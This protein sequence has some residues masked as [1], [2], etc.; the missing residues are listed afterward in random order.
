MWGVYAHL[1]AIPGIQLPILAQELGL[2]HCNFTPEKD[3]IEILIT[4]QR[5]MRPRPML[6]GFF[7]I[8]I[9]RAEV[10]G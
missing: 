8:W 10:G 1:A 3:Y 2:G 4:W 6:V 7:Q 5:E 9:D